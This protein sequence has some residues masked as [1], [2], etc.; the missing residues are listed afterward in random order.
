MPS[1][2]RGKTTPR[3]VLLAGSALGLVLILPSPVVARTVTA[4]AHSAPATVTARGSGSSYALSYS[5]GRV[6]RWN[7]C[8]VIHYRVNTARAP[9]GALLTSRQQWRD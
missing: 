3:A 7:P 2:P 9:K 6:V 8:R 4:P 1:S 5:S